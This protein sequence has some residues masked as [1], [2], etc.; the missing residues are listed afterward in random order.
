VRRQPHR[1]KK[2]NADNSQ[3][4]GN[5]T[6]TKSANGC[7]YTITVNDVEGTG[8]WKG[9]RKLIEEEVEDE[10][11]KL[12]ALRTVD[13]IIDDPS[14]K[15]MRGT[16]PHGLDLFAYT[17]TLFRVRLPHVRTLGPHAFCGCA[18]LKTVEAPLVE[19]MEA[20]AFML[21][22]GLKKVLIAKGKDAEKR[23]GMNVW[24]T[25]GPSSSSRFTLDSF[26][27]NDEHSTGAPSK[28]KQKVDKSS[29]VNRGNDGE[30][31]SPNAEAGKG[32]RV[33]R[34]IGVL[35]NKVQDA[36]N[37]AGADGI[38]TRDLVKAVGCTKRRLYDVINVL[39]GTGLLESNKGVGP[40]LKKWRW[41]GKYTTS[42]QDGS[43]WKDF[44]DE[45][46][47]EDDDLAEADE[48]DEEKDE[49]LPLLTHDLFGGLAPP[50]HTL[51]GESEN[52][53]PSPS[54]SQVNPPPQPH[55]PTDQP[56]ESIKNPADTK[57]QEEIA[58][59]EEELSFLSKHIS[60][61][62]TQNSSARS[63]A[64]ITKSMVSNLYGAGKKVVVVGVEEGAKV[65]VGVAGPGMGG[66]VRISANSKLKVINCGV[67]IRLG[68]RGDEEV[69]GIE[70]VEY[71][72]GT[73]TSRYK[74]EGEE[75]EVEEV[76][77]KEDVKKEDL[78]MSVDKRKP[79]DNGASKEVVSIDKGEFSD[80]SSEVYV[81]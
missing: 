20:T 5:T 73:V 18:R 22:K 32:K 35:T 58:K 9:V 66:N 40:K 59:A 36:V 72:G 48:V 23:F 41:A 54:P 24:K 2:K 79:V 17:R 28:K 81:S 80:A 11:D 46:E 14:A 44:G 45:S 10:E 55:A 16:S 3:T 49:E 12:V 60:E 33:R 65:N 27:P 34:S 67:P 21:C 7:K 38:L 68:A 19:E 29:A 56:P 50:T 63:S 25:K 13:L 64:Y 78:S 15:V 6:I 71:S 53:P 62:Q 4:V 76:E 47:E 61:T 42:N 30:D 70:I 8:G 51:F 57:R 31:E 26:A 75:M 1:S 77:E 69:D 37:K 52:V 74:E 39:S 43:W